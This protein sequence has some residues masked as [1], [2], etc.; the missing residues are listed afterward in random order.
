MTARR[1]A[2][3]NIDQ[4]S[5]PG[6]GTAAEP[7]AAPSLAVPTNKHELEPR[8]LLPKDLQAV[9]LMRA[10][11]AD[12]LTKPFE[13]DALLSRAKSLVRRRSASREFTLG[14]SQS[15]QGTEDLI[16]RIA[17]H[18]S[19]VLFA[20]ETGVGKDICARLLHAKSPFA[21]GSCSWPST[22]RQFPTTFLESEVFGHEKGAFTGASARHLGYAERAQRGT[23]FLDE[24]AELPACPQ[25]KLLRLI[26]EKGFYRVGGEKAVPFRARDRLREQSRSCPRSRRGPIPEKTC[27][28]A[29]TSL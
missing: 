17:G 6:T 1:P 28:T 20:G 19:P 24:V 5:T 26:D 22:A 25:A 18:P 10:G 11:A 16:R 27:F 3:I 21:D 2:D 29:S 4:S 13:I 7:N 15:M 14:V 8:H 23:L 9:D 12:Y